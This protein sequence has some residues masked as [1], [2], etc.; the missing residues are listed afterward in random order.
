MVGS[1][2]SWQR[3]FHSKARVSYYAMKVLPLP[4]FKDKLNEKYIPHLLLP[5]YKVLYLFFLSFFLISVFVF[6]FM[7]FWT[8]IFVF[9]FLL[10]FVFLFRIF[11]F[12][13][14]NKMQQLAQSKDHR[15]HFIKLTHKI[16]WDNNEPQKLR[17]L[18]VKTV[19]T[20]GLSWGSWLHQTLSYLMFLFFWR[21]K[22]ISRET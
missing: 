18:Q 17:T 1:N 21:S 20:E 19:L 8:S 3:P 12:T 4:A 10:L 22:G 14:K 15:F 2:V 7:L 6:V 16:P 5:H 13:V 11:M 9:G